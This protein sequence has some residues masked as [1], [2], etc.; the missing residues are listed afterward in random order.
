M[1]REK[2]KNTF[3]LKLFRIFFPYSKQL[4]KFYS[5]IYL[6]LLS[7]LHLF[8]HW[9]IELATKQFSFRNKAVVKKVINHVIDLSFEFLIPRK[10]KA[11]WSANKKYFFHF[12]SNISSLKLFMHCI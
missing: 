3:L 10:I 12:A 11:R 7:F 8:F 9:V 6:F 1:P 4:K 2:E 5:S